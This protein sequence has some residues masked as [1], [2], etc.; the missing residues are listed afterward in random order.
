MGITRHVE[1][2]EVEL[3][4]EGGL[5]GSEAREVAVGVGEGEADLDE[6]EAVDVGLEDGVVRGGSTVAEF[7]VGSGVGADHDTGE[8]GVHGDARV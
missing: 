4:D 3:P 7:V 1:V 8:F 2:A 6:V 5:G